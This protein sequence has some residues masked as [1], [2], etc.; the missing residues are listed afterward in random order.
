MHVDT[1]AALAREAV[2]KLIG[3]GLDPDE[4]L[5]E[6]SARVRR[7]VPHDSSAWMTLDPDTLLPNGAL[8]C[9]RG[10][11]AGNAGVPMASLLAAIRTC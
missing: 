6:V 7:V 1:S 10:A 8:Q 3:G 2:R 9:M 11:A 5:H 4:F